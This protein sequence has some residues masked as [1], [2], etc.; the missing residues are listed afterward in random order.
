MD[1]SAASTHLHPRLRV[2]VTRAVH[3]A[4]ALGDALASYGLLVVAIPAIELAE[5]TDEYEGL[6]TALQS[7]D[8]FDWLLFTSAN[9]V[10]VFAEQREELAVEEVPCR[11][12]SIGAATSRALRS[13]G[14]RVDLQ[15]EV[16]VA[17]AFAR[18][19]RPH[20]RGRRMLLVRAE[21]ARDVLPMEIARAGGECMVA[22]AYRTVVPQGSVEALRR[23]LPGVAAVTFT[24]SSAVRNLLELCDA[25]GV[26]LPPSAVL[27]S[28]GP[29]TT[30][31][32]HEAGYAVT[33]ESSVAQVEVL[34][35]ELAR[36]LRRRGL[37][38]V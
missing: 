24:S 26:T 1:S 20:A 38:D 12:A 28:I 13:A 35:S 3:Q 21:A 19:L 29:I 33:V 17:E 16:A 2:L 4:S 10:A 7:L 25:A 9:A 11:I 6:H 31:T 34:A 22:A 36:Y 18:A 37:S 5:P 15:P 32:L 14:L 30:A 8:E 27:A 23:E